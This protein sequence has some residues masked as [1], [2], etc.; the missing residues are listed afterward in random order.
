MRRPSLITSLLLLAAVMILV[1][2]GN[3][4]PDRDPEEG[5][6]VG[7]SSVAN[8]VRA[9][10]LRSD[11]FRA[12]LQGRLENDGDPAALAMWEAEG[13]ALAEARTKRLAD[14]MRRDPRAA[15]E[16]SLRWDEWVALPKSVRR[17]TEQPFSEMVGQDCYVGCDPDTGISTKELRIT[18][19]DGRDLRAYGFGRRELALSRE[20]VPMQGFELGG[21]AVVG[22][23]AFQI[24]TSREASA[25]RKMFAAS[26]SS[27]GL[28]LWSGEP[29][30]HDAVDVLI[31]GRLEQISPDEVAPLRE[32]LNAWDSIPGEPP[33]GER[34]AAWLDP[35]NP[36]AFAPLNDDF[37]AP[38]DA[39]PWTTTPKRLLLIRVD[40][41]DLV[42]ARETAE[43][44][45][46]KL[47]TAVSDSL[48]EMSY[49]KTRLIVTV[50]PEVIRMPQP[51]TYYPAEQTAGR[52]GNEQ[53]HSAARSGVTALGYVLSDYD[54]WCV[55]FGN[56]GMGYGGLAILG[57]QKS[58][59]Q[60]SGTSVFVHE[61]GHNYGLGHANR[62]V[63]D[64]VDEPIGP[65]G[66]QVD[67][68][69]TSSIMGSGPFPAGHFDSQAK[70]F[71]GWLD[72]TQWVDVASSGRYRLWRADHFQSPRPGQAGGIRIG[73]DSLPGDSIWLSY[74]RAIPERRRLER[75]VS[76]IWQQASALLNNRLVKAGRNGSFP[77]TDYELPVGQTFTTGAIHVTPVSRGGTPPWQWI[78]LE[79]QLDPPSGNTHPTASWSSSPP[80]E[81]PPFHTFR[82]D[83]SAGDADGDPLAYHWDP[84]DGSEVSFNGPS[85]VHTYRSAGLYQLSV[86][87]SDMRGG[88]TILAKTIDVASESSDWTQRASGTTS[89]LNHIAS[90]PQRAVAVSGSGH[91]IHSSDGENWTVLDLRS[92][93]GL[94][95]LDLREIGWDGTCFITIG[96]ERAVSGGAWEGC[97][98]RS[99]DGI[100]WT[101][102]HIGGNL[103]WRLA[104][105]GG[106]WVAGGELSTMRK[107]TDG[108]TWTSVAFP[109]T[110]HVNGIAYGNGVWLAVPDS[111]SGRTWAY[112]SPDLQTWTYRSWS[113][114]FTN[115]Q[116][117]RPV[118]WM[119]GQFYLG[120]FVVGLRN[121][122]GDG[123]DLGLTPLLSGLNIND[124]IEVNGSL[125]VVGDITENSVQKGHVH[126]SADGSSWQRIDLTG[127]VM[128]R[129][130]TSF[131]GRLI[132]VGNA[133]EIWQS[134]PLYAPVVNGWYTWQAIHRSV[135]GAEDDPWQILPGNNLPNLY[136]YALGIDPDEPS[137]LPRLAPDGSGK[138]ALTVPR[139]VIRPDVEYRTLRSIDLQSWT[140]EG[141]EILA[142]DVNA[143]K[144]RASD[145]AIV[146]REFLR[147]EARLAP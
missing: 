89:Q 93:R 130:V 110:D 64:S 98:Y 109:T 79:I 54:F 50:T 125:Y 66:T 35:E 144:A 29:V 5:S 146:D 135:L 73:L 122:S 119:A 108:V 94:N 65:N 145:P 18:R 113:E 47:S 16:E 83:V 24:L 57:G 76:V 111:N 95:A 13:F 58:W 62:W 101:R 40:F 55:Q 2:S 97:V 87:I 115:N 10:T 84:G 53:M 128:M 56:I 70:A 9:E 114:V 127:P 90:S 126:V 67:Y 118:R 33:G 52:N 147:F 140:T 44:L 75:G 143:F 96:R 39:S 26:P 20:R 138:M 38:P 30:G 43:V 1:A 25:A 106:H 45:T 103:L 107:S 15:L 36:G 3:R 68:G 19:A 6:R 72:E 11:D 80:D 61:F 91:I 63:P 136:H 104:H 74:K 102:T 8:A 7:E 123:L 41:P 60:S 129:G 21:E 132:T 120:G 137:P 112:T 32:R 27:R 46:T 124:M 28:S 86:L 71:L 49:G 69:S 121:V 23:E 34:L 81:V 22:A 14:L 117:V 142:D 42:G 139:S 99:T 85:L 116:I 82:L 59:I 133:G 4:R 51:S 141:V 78:D 134:G 17:V 131:G 92:V 12:W 31:G 105:G 88:K 37:F 48:E 100:T 77:E